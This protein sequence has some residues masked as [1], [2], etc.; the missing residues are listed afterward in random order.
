MSR[1]NHLIPCPEPVLFK[2]HGFHK[3]LHLNVKAE[4]AELLK[5]VFLNFIR[6]KYLTKY[7]ISIL[8]KLSEISGKVKEKSF[9]S[10]SGTSSLQT[11]WISQNSATQRK[12]RAGRTAQERVF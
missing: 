11:A 6:A 7:S 9:D 1:K 8:S 12:G 2:V 10:L 3:I 5:K 4:L